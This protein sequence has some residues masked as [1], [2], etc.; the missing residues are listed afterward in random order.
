MEKNYRKIII[1]II[2][3]LFT[4]FTHKARASEL[5]GYISCSPPYAFDTTTSTF[6]LS[7]F[8]ISSCNV[9]SYLWDYGNGTT[10]TLVDGGGCFNYPS[11]YNIKVTCVCD[12]GLVDTISQNIYFYSH[13]LY[14]CSFIGTGAKEI[15][16]NSIQIYPNP[17]SGEFTIM[18]PEHNAHL[19]VFT[20]TGIQVLSDELQFGIN[21]VETSSLVQGIYFVEYLTDT[22]RKNT[23]LIK[24]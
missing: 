23:Y 24:N 14:D 4:N 15:E 2:L 19:R 20:S 7:L 11:L 9:V 13:F 16:N 1:G 17:T 8:V 18:N 6:C 21:K 12:N 5:Y 3:F 10:S 22:K